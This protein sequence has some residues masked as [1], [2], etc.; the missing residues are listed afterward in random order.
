MTAQFRWKHQPTFP[1]RINTADRY[2]KSAAFFVYRTAGRLYEAVTGTPAVTDT[3][4]AVPGVDPF[5]GPCLT[6]NY[7]GSQKSIFANLP[8]F[9]CVGALTVLALVK[10]KTLT[11]Y[12]AVVS[13]EDTPDANGFEIRIGLAATDSRLVYGR[14]NSV[15]HYYA[16]SADTIAA[17]A[18][19]YLGF[20]RGPDI[21]ITGTHI[22]V[23]ATGLAQTFTNPALGE[24]GAGTGTAGAGQK[25]YVG[26]RADGVTQLDGSIHWIIGFNEELTVSDLEEIRRRPWSLLIPTRRRA[27]FGVS[28]GALAPRSLTVNQAVNRASTY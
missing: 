8:A 3:S 16:E 18:V 25:L 4:V 27:Y 10:P 19:S 2:G 6:A 23:H 17:G 11:N 21:G 7:S 15:N 26:Q 24:A 22:I 9:D 13:S 28:G 20:I 5:N 12:S 14:A 1:A